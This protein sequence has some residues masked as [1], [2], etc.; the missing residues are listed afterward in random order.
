[1][2]LISNSVSLRTIS[3]RTT[4][5]SFPLLALISASQSPRLPQSARHSHSIRLLLRQSRA[6]VQTQATWIRYHLWNP[7][8]LHTHRLIRL[9]MSTRLQLFPHHRN[10]LRNTSRYLRIQFPHHRNPQR[11]QIL[12][13][14]P[15]HSSFYALS[16]FLSSILA[17]LRL[18]PLHLRPWPRPRC[19]RICPYRYPLPAA[20]QL[21]QRM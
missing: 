6:G 21:C 4:L 8:P 2:C 20:S 5:Q 13:G 1:M 3:L 15:T 11:N 14:Y 18:R 12:D 10:T 7:V 16:L 17:N 19:L 9:W